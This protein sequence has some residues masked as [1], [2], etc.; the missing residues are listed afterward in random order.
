MP[1]PHAAIPTY[2]PPLHL[3]RH[4]LRESSYLPPTIQSAFTSLIRTR[5]RRHRKPDRLQDAHRAKAASALRK[6]RAANSGDKSR[7]ENLLMESFGRIGARRRALLSDFLRKQGPSDSD[8]LEALIQEA[9]ADR[10]TSKDNAAVPPKTPVKNNTFSNK[11]EVEATST[12]A[13]EEK[14]SGPNSARTRAGPKTT[15]PI[16]YDKWD[17]AK[18]K[19]L[20]LA[21]RSL[22]LSATLPWPKRDLRSLNDE[23]Q[24]PKETI[25]GKPPPENVIRAKKAHFWRRTAT[26]VMP[27]LSGSEW[28]LLGRLSKG[29]QEEEEG[30]DIPERRPAAIP[31]HTAEPEADWNWEKYASQPVNRIE[32]KRPSRVM[33]FV[34]LENKDME[35]YQTRYK[36]SEISPRWFRRAY[37]R[38]WQFVPKLNPDARQRNE[39]YAW[40]TLNNPVVPPS[41]RQLDIFEGVNSNGQPLKKP[42][43]SDVTKPT[44]Q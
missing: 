26:K 2:L 13:S 16:F 7:M 5:F 4:M 6:L 37:K 8:A 29:A 38:V 40:G 27:P 18:L 32:R 14:Q 34:G 39:M 11:P 31:M 33:P 20:L 35:P 24:L 15:K 41:R 10:K 1:R 30:W 22:Q 12:M 3:Y 17:T 43:A 9:D 44:S 25:W 23:A 42:S 28:E 19:P 21:Q 36:Q